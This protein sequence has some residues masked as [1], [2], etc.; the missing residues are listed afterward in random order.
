MGDTLE[1]TDPREING[2]AIE[3]LALIGRGNRAKN[4]RGLAS[5]QCDNDSRERTRG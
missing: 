4:W 5:D 2:F 1:I 3:S